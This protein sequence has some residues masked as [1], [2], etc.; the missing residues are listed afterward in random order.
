MRTPKMLAGLFIAL[1]LVGTPGR[2]VLFT[3]NSTADFPDF[4]VG[5]GECR[6]NPGGSPICTLRAAVQ[7]A[8]QLSGADQIVLPAGTYNLTIPGSDENW[9]ATG[10]LDIVDDLTIQGSGAG[11]TII[12]GINAPQERDRI[13][14]VLRVLEDPIVE[15]RDLT[16]KDG[17]E[18]WGGGIAISNS[19][20]TLA[21][22]ALINNTAFGGGGIFT[23]NPSSTV[24]TE[25][26]VMSNFTLGG[27]AVG[28]GIWNNGDMTIDSS[29]ILANVAGDVGGGIH[30]LGTLHV[31]NSTIGLNSA[32]SDGGGIYNAGSLEIASSTLTGNLSGAA[33]DDLYYS[34]GSDV[35]L[36]NS[37]LN[38]P[39]PA[40][41]CAGLG[42]LTSVGYNLENGNS[43]GLTHPT[44]LVNT[45]PQLL[46]PIDNGGPTLTFAL[47]PSSPAVDALNDEPSPCTDLGGAPLTRDQ[48]GWP[49]PSDGDLDGVAYCDIGSFELV[50]EI[51]NDGFESGDTSSWSATVP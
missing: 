1:T 35:L 23:A 18:I 40:A 44:D 11:A 15:I 47:P 6:I 22:V 19:A 8:N 3:V 36:R 4:D 7:Q 2:A 17:E 45:D 16:I 51:F 13:F 37:I 9:A 34:S 21:N 42:T 27:A 25:V 39:S 30:N 12:D 50:L 32:T 46:P 33:G 31:L 14:H 24:L 28:A 10:D 26:T 43:C 48:R 49:R 5:D 41:S 29:A 38:S 20:V